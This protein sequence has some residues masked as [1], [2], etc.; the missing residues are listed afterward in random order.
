LKASYDAFKI[1]QVEVQTDGVIASDHI[2]RWAMIKP[3]QNLLALDLA[4]VKRDLELVP[5]IQSASVERILPNA[6]KIRVSEREPVAQIPMMQLKAGGGYEQVLY[7]VDNSGFI[8][9]PLDPRL[10]AK[11]AGS[12]AQQLPVISGVDARELRAGCRVEAEQ[13]RAALELIRQFD[14]SSMFGYVDLLRMDL[15]IPEILHL[16]TAQGSEVFFALE[17]FDRQLH[18]WRLVYDQSQRWGK[19]IGSLDL[20]VANNAPLR[21]VE[22]TPSTTPRLKNVKPSSRGKKKNV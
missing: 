16:Y 7:H 1:R 19:A 12:S 2:R 3:N 20:S 14:R 10:R 5:L 18:R 15:S 17:N 22:A 13:I 8:F 4:K 6:L 9:H 21:L 11:S